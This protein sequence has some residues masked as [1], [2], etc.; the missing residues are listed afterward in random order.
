MDI[1][2]VHGNYPGQ[3]LHLARKLGEQK[4]H[5]IFFITGREDAHTIPLSGVNIRKFNQHRNASV[6]IHDYLK[7]M[8]NAVLRGQAVLREL[9]KL[10]NE[11]IFPRLI[12]THGGNGLAL[13]IRQIFPFAK[14]IL[15]LEWWFGDE[16][17]QWLLQNYT[18]NDK[19]KSQLRN[20]ISLLELDTCDH[21]VVP[22]E[23]QLK[24]FPLQHQQKFSVLFDGVNT[25]FFYPGHV[26][27][28]CSFSIEGTQDKVT[29]NP[30]DRLITYATRGMEPVRGFPEFM[31]ILP[32][33]L[34]TYHDLKVIIAG[35]D[36]AAYSYSAPI[37][38][39]SW[40]E[41]MLSFI[42]DSCDTSRIFFTGLLPLSEYRQ[43]LWRTN[44][45][46]YFSRPYITSW[47]LFQA[48]A[49]G[50]PLLLNHG[51]WISKFLKTD[52]TNCY[53]ELDDP[54]DVCTKALE[55]LSDV[56]IKDQCLVKKSKIC[57]YYSLDHAILSW[58]KFMNE[59][60]R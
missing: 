5:R 12:I 46:V 14:I 1:V 58:Q 25:S 32:K 38:S 11:N 15:Y 6:S 21:A 8:E 23:W 48:A 22:T 3:F 16:T 18:F 60:L 51:E 19:L 40:K 28:Q 44:L 13:F 54:N 10:K 34:S 17:N 2:F 9:V 29:I 37:A 33:L 55:C 43:L 20:S 4:I 49:C 30:Q 53:C 41:Y 56:N 42:S 26:D 7:P 31:E 50:T 39:G 24:Q 27:H 36:R 47:G 59:I 57:S 52:Q 35:R 45:H